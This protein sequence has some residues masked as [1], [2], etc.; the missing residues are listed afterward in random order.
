MEGWDSE[1]EFGPAP[2]VAGV[3]SNQAYESGQVV[4]LKR[5][6]TLE[7]L[8]GDPLLLNFKEGMRE[9]CASMGVSRTLLYDAS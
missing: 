8:E 3:F 5:I 9:E 4:V 1:D 6:F 7:E 2:V